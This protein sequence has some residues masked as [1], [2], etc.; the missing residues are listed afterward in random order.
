M[1]ITLVIIFVIFNKNDDL[2][3]KM[4]VFKFLRIPPMYRVD[5]E[6]S[7]RHIFDFRN[8]KP[9]IQRFSKTGSPNRES[10]IF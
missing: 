10:K 4:K 8:L 5:P 9:E 1:E 7:Q 6:N 2:R 3:S